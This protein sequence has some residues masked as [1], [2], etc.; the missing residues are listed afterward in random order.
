MHVWSGKEVFSI[1]PPWFR[2]GGILNN[3]SI[4]HGGILI[5]TSISGM[6]VFSI[7]P[8]WLRHAD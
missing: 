1:I 2:H 5:N 8:T 6:G 7:I 4:R 3:T